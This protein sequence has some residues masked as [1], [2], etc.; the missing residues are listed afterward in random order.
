MN[1][2][3][4]GQIALCAALMTAVSISGGGCL[5]R[6]PAV[7]HFML[8]TS[9]ST[10]TLARAADMAVLVGPVRLPAYL[11]RSQIATLEGGG[12]ISLNEFNR[13]LGGFEEN[14]L[15]ALSLGLA[16]ELGSTKIVA[17]PSKAPFEID[18]QIRLHV[19][20]LIFEDDGG[21]RVRVRWALIPV[22]E[23]GPPGLFVMDEFI[24]VDANSVESVVGAHENAL[25]DLVRR[26]ADALIARDSDG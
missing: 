7:R 13:W 6:S 12:E 2:R 18:Y 23:E 9:E 15:R 14:F 21:L 25:M 19:D 20:D 24:R 1:G 26:I 22:A 4:M 8:G 17:A 3:F 5:G 16:Q 11:D 10:S